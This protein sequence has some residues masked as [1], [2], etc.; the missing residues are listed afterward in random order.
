MENSRGFWVYAAVTG[1]VA[2]FGPWATALLGLSGHADVAAIIAMMGGAVYAVTP[3]SQWPEA[4][5]LWGMVALALLASLLAAGIGI[6]L[7]VALGY[8]MLQALGE[9]GLSVGLAPWIALTF[10]TCARAVIYLAIF[11]AGWSVV[12][13]RG[14]L[15][16]A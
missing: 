15:A 8:S 4:T 1:A 7:T 3:K 5:R 6:G 14:Q 9:Q 10:A 11:A 13:P 2:V 12:R 16:E